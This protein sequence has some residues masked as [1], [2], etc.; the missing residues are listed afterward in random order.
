MSS[1]YKRQLF[2]VVSLGLF[3][4]Y[5]LQKNW[6]PI[7]M[8]I[9]QWSSLFLFTS[10]ARAATLQDVCT[11]AYVQ[12]SL[13]VD[14]VNELLSPTTITIDPSSVVAL[15][16]TNA[17]ISSTTWYPAGTI[18][19]C[20]VTFAYSH[21]GRNDRVTVQYF[22]PTPANFK[23]RYLSTG[24]GGYAIN[25]GTQI[26]PG[27]I[28]NGAVAGL[29]DGGFGSFTTQFDQVFLLANGTIN[30]QS[31]YMFGYQG[32][33][34]LTVIGKQLT[35]NFFN[36]T[37]TKLYAYYQGCSEGGREGW[38][39]VQRFGEE[40]DGAITGAPAFRFAHQQVQHLWSNVVE[41]TQGYVPPQCELDKI[42]NATIEACD[43][44]DGKTDGV[45]AR[46]D[47]C[48]LQFNASRITGM[49]YSC[50]AAA[51]NPSVFPAR[52]A[53][54]AQNSTVTA[55]GVAVTQEII[56]GMHDL[57]GQQV[58]FQYQPAASF[59][60]AQTAYDFDTNQWE[61]SISGLGGEFVERYL[62]LLNASNIPTLE[63]VTYDTLKEWIVDGWTKYADS[64]QTTWP[65]LTPFNVAGG[66]VL[67]YHGE[68]DNS[69]PTASSVRYWESVR[70]IM[71]P[72]MTYN[73]SAN[74]LKEWYKLF[75][76]PGMAHCAPN[77]LQP[78][79]PFP[80]TNLPVLIDWVEN[81]VEPTT[82]NATHL[83][84]PD[85]GQPAQICAWPLRAIWTAA[86]DMECVYDQA[87]IDTWHYDL[88]AYKVPVY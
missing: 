54:P 17:L 66:K 59:A 11:N 55:Q 28:M 84:G 48:K 58:Y 27:G 61:I 42:V 6:M 69:I 21:N 3:S 83:A 87:S 8:Q 44:L 32:I 64:L 75:L 53:Y 25:S 85:M 71:Y 23:N 63:N 2:A 37:N 16:V 20:N 36:S 47:L 70:E 22:L 14:D 62:Y 30:Y 13:P 68:A 73:D 74:A 50:P 19:Y 43:S 5:L 9:S 29:T 40:L 12:A 33:Q 56:D 46:S 45:V 1:S 80:Q 51:Y 81:G 39:Q 7:N 72:N 49:P 4:S 79:G 82:L 52:N 24:G 67:H 18:D 34:E 41:Q 78:N 60:D 57:E 35:K 38:S 15:P 76:V 77:P 86:G 10:I 26:L 31:L 65:D 88:N